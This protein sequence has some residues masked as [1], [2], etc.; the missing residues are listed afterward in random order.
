[1]TEDYK[2]VTFSFCE[3]ESIY[4]EEMINSLINYLVNAYIYKYPIANF[5]NKKYELLVGFLE[6][7]MTA[8]QREILRC[9]Y[10]RQETFIKEE[11]YPLSLKIIIQNEDGFKASVFIDVDETTGMVDDY[12]I[13]CLSEFYRGLSNNITLE[14]LME[15][16]GEQNLPFVDYSD[17]VSFLKERKEIKDI[18]RRVIKAV[19]KALYESDSIRENG[20]YR[21][22]K[23]LEEFILFYD[24]DMDEKEIKKEVMQNNVVKRK[25]KRICN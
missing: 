19:A 8:K 6:K 14:R 16:M 11:G 15:I 7:S 4:D 23:F 22:E 3:K 20:K 17:I 5:V 13:M 9:P 2:E 1:M 24:I 25:K 12:S 18:R 10:S 21:M